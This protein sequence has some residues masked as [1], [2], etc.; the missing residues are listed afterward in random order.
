[1]IG[2]GKQ[3]DYLPV[4][5]SS[6]CLTFRVFFVVLSVV[7][8]MGKPDFMDVDLDAS[9]V[10]G[11]VSIERLNFR[12]AFVFNPRRDDCDDFFECLD[13]ERIRCFFDF[14]SRR[15]R[16]DWVV[17]VGFDWVV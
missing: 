6:T 1:M 16:F 11:V 12:V 3:L 4:F 14:K 10:V 9:L 5:T 13:C 17:V 8:V 15:V 7:V 2:R